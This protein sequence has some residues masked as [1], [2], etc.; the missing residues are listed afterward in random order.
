[1]ASELHDTSAGCKAPSEDPKAAR[2]LDRCAGGSY[3][4]LAVGLVRGLRN[5]G[6]RQPVDTTSVDVEE[7]AVDELPYDE[8]NAAGGVKM[9]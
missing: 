2:C 1:M 4:L 3:D 9:R 6:D 5:L 8:R 7:T